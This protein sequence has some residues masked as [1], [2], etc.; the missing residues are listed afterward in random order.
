MITKEKIS[1][2]Y[3]AGELRFTASRS[4]GPGGQ[5]VNKVSTKVTLIFDVENSE[6]LNEEEKEKI[7]NI[8]SS[9]ISKAGILQISSSEKR[10]QLQNKE[11]AIA[12]FDKLL[13]KAFARKKK[14]KATKPT[15]ASRKKR[16]ETKKK[17]GEKKKWRQSKD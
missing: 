17:Q 15:A 14:R 11:T 12:K 1:A 16:L 6:L 10:T 2:A 4:G 3:L 7:K 5:N 13:T 8:R 9:Y